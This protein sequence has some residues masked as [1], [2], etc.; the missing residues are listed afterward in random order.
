ME[1]QTN[2]VI[3]MLGK[4]DEERMKKR[5]KDGERDRERQIER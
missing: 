4:G 5:E 1:C 2:T 3:H